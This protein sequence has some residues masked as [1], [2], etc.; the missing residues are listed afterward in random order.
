M[1]V[2]RFV[3]LTAIASTLAMVACRPAPSSDF[4]ATN[5]EYELRIAMTTRPVRLSN[6]PPIDDSVALSISFDSVNAD[7]MFGRYGEGLERIG[8]PINDG[9]LGPQMVSVRMAGDAFTLTLAPN[10]LDAMVV[11]EGHVRQGVGYGTWK[12]IAPSSAAGTFVMR[13]VK[14]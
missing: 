4:W 5:Q 6:L 14:P 9:G 3:R 2:P 13:K 11:M 7:S 8:M 10:V 1:T 12:P